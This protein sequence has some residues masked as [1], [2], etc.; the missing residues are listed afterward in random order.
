[1][2]DVPQLL[3]LQLCSFF[4][5]NAV[6]LKLSFQNLNALGD[7]VNVIFKVAVPPVHLLIRRSGQTE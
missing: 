6:P 4:N 1:M 7:N 5:S 3:C 2:T